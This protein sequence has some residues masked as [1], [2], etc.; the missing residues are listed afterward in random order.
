MPFAPG[1]PWVTIDGVRMECRWIGPSPTEAPTVVML[2]EGLGSVGQWKNFPDRIAEATGCGVFV[3]SRQGYGGSDPVEVPRPLSYMHDE[4]LQVLPKLLDAIG[5]RR[6]LLVGH[7]DG[8]SIA[9][10][11]AGG[12]E[13]HRVRGL[14]LL[15]PHFFVEPVSVESIRKARHAYETG[16]LRARLKK[17]HGSNIDGAFWGWN[18]AWLDPEFLKWNIEDYIAYIRVPILVLQGADD[19][20]GTLR[21]IEVAEEEAYCPVDRAIIPCCGHAPH[22]E[23]PEA[24]LA[25]IREYA[26]RL[27]VVHGE[28]ALV[29]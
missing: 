23:E 15:A 29:A 28:A 13:D 16:D 2:H 25:A 9:T 1:D 12:V 6:G 11:Y 20:Y 8:A 17:Y 10:I 21:Q 3:Y 18:R 7:S 26:E 4:A 19:P 14:V 5:F 24:T 22:L 27:L